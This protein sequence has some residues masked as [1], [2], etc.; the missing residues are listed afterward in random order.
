MNWVQ[1]EVTRRKVDVG[2]QRDRFLFAYYRTH[3]I[4]AAVDMLASVSRIQ[5]EDVSGQRICE[6][7]IPRDSRQLDTRRSFVLFDGQCGHVVKDF[8]GTEDC[9]SRCVFSEASDPSFS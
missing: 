1:E 3:A 4:I 5:W 7:L 2:Y 6:D 9:H 8:V